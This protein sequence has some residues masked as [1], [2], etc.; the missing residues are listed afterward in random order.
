MVLIGGR[1]VHSGFKKGNLK[2]KDDLEDLEE[3]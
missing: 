2:E 3:D 1:E